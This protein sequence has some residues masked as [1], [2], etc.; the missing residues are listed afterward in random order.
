MN[1]N[2]TLLTSLVALSLV[3]FT[4]CSNDDN[5]AEPKMVGSCTIVDKGDGTS[6]IRCPD[7][8]EIVVKNGTNGAPG[9]DGNNGKDGAQGQSGKDGKD[10]KDPS[11]CTLTDNADGTQ[12][13]TCGT[14]SVVIGDNCEQGFPS[15]VVVTDPSHDEGILLTLF[16]ATSCT[17]IRGDL[18]VAEYPG[19][20]LPKALS[21][22]EQVDGSVVIG[23]EDYGNEALTS[24]SFPNLA[25]VGSDLIIEENHALTQLDGFPVLEHVGGDF[26]VWANPELVNVGDFPALKSVAMLDFWNNPKL[27]SIGSFDELESAEAMYW[28]TSEALTDM[29]RFPKLTSVQGFY[30]YYNDALETLSEF[31]ALETIDGDVQI[32]DNA[33]L[34]SLAGLSAVQTITGDVTIVDN[35]KLAQC[36]VDELLDG[37]DVQGDMLVELNDDDAT[38]P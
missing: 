27:V 23:F 8:S 10:G 18:V 5:G 14:T 33:E 28:E 36:H 22:I 13:L 38:C 25:I 32:M 30:V 34:T 19:E 15:D 11:P 29:G 9:E 16:Q 17:W 35:A 26:G 4:G 3:A 7:G 12:T 1:R 20:Q 6:A 21:R 37:I 31:P 24:I 2:F